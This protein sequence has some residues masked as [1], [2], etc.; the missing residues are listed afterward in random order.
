MH[1]LV[2]RNKDTFFRIILV[3][4]TIKEILLKSILQKDHLH[5]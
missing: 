3:T 4:I 5:S 1:L 2:Q